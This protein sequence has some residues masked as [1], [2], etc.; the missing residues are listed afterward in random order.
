MRKGDA[1]STVYLKLLELVHFYEGLIDNAVNQ[2][3]SYSNMMSRNRL[4]NAK[5]KRATTAKKR[6][7]RRSVP[8]LDLMGN[9]IG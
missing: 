7:E 6:E 3:I 1:D 8:N 4:A 5:Y 9:V 2:Q